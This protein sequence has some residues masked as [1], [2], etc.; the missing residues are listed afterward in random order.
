M[1]IT[2]PV[3]RGTFCHGRTMSRTHALALPLL[4]VASLLQ[5]RANALLPPPVQ[6]GYCGATMC[7]EAG[8]IA[9][10]WRST[11]PTFTSSSSPGLGEIIVSYQGLG[12]VSL[13]L[14]EATPE[15]CRGPAERAELGGA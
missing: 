3:G 8:V 9:M 10:P 5:S 2:H 14:D 1:L 4:C 7:V 12:S 13:R 6:P 15:D 11:S